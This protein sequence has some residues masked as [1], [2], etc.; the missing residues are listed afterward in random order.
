MRVSLQ[1]HK[2]KKLL[3]AARAALAMEMRK[4]VCQMDTVFMQ[5]CREI[6]SW[7]NTCTPPTKKTKLSMGY[8]Q[9]LSLWRGV[10]ITDVGQSFRVQG[11]RCLSDYNK[12]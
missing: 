12:A 9:A 5:R 2:D 11:G 7:G 3:E 6:I 8:P 10:I 1:R 4:P